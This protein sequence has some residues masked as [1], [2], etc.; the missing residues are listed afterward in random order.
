MNILLTET[1]LGRYNYD[2]LQDGLIFLHR[3]MGIEFFVSLQGIIIFY[4]L[5]VR[6]KRILRGLVEKFHLSAEGWQP[7]PEEEPIEPD[8][9]NGT[10]QNWEL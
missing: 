3:L 2:N 8:L 7:C 5:V 4:I 10:E 1:I 9:E 6:R